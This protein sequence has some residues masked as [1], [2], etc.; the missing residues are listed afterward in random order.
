M[1]VL[2]GV[3]AIVVGLERARTGRRE[4]S[5]RWRAWLVLPAGGVVAL[6]AGAPRGYLLV[7][8]LGL[9]VMPL[10]LIWS[11]LLFLVLF[12]WWTHRR[13]E[14]ATSAALLVALTLSTNL[15]LSYVLDAWTEGEQLAARPFSEGH[16]D[17]VIVLGGGTDDR[18]GGE[19]EL[20][21]SGDRVML[22]ARLYGA[23]QTPLL[24]TSGSPIAGLSTHD[25]ARATERIWR[26]LG[27]PERAIV[28]VDGARTTS[29]EAR[30]HAQLISERGLTRVGL[31][32]SGSH[33]RR[34]LG[35]FEAEGVSLVPLPADLRGRPFQWHGFYSILPQGRAADRIQADLWELVGRLAGR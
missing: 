26:Q 3:I 10:G 12:A 14:A 28:V 1:L 22:G 25:A 21:P 27:I 32:T 7:K 16:F 35:L 23:G 5:S 13:C 30:L 20:G 11:A 29:E 4:G 19:V 17:A 9:L 24:I 18:P 31:V 33:M 34:A 2:L 8:S 15:P 6:I